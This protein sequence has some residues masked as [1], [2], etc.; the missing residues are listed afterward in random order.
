MTNNLVLNA[1][2][3][4]EYAK[5]NGF[6]SVEFMMISPNIFKGKFLDAYY[7]MIQIPELGEGFIM[8][9]ELI[10]QCGFDDLKFMVLKTDEEKIL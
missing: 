3:L 7:G 5:D 4:E 9:K 1:Y 8:L 10:K 2:E 6:D